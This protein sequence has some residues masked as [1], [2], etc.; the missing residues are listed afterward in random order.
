MSIM[1]IVKTGMLWEIVLYQINYVDRPYFYTHPDQLKKMKLEG[2]NHE[3]EAEKTKDTYSTSKQETEFRNEL[4]HHRS[5]ESSNFTEERSNFKRLREID[6]ETQQ[7]SGNRTKINKHSQSSSSFN[8]H[9][10]N[11]GRFPNLRSSVSFNDV[12][13][14]NWQQRKSNDLSRQYSDS[15]WGTPKRSTYQS[16]DSL[17]MNGLSQKLPLSSS[18][19]DYKSK[20]F[21]LDSDSPVKRSQKYRSNSRSEFDSNSRKE[22]RFE[23]KSEREQDDGKTCNSWNNE[24]YCRFR[25]TCWY[26]HCCAGCGNQDHR[27][28]DCTKI[29]HL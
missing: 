1:N 23:I 19:N 29:R 7:S 26:S 5:E 6:D 18:K 16:Q 13:S 4:R 14:E 8:H 3:S 28:M 12:Q 22:N 17:I 25:D 15:D 9:D 21:H 24:G 2:Y 20:H 27:I 11:N 10:H